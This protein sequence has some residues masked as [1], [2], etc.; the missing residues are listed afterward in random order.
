[1]SIVAPGFANSTTPFY[2]GTKCGNI[3]QTDTY[4]T[5]GAQPEPI[6]FTDPATWSDTQSFTT[7]DDITWECQTTGVYTLKFNQTFDVTNTYTPPNSDTRVTPSTTFYLDISGNLEAP[8]VGDLLVISNQGAQSSVIATVG[9]LTE[10][11]LM[12][13]FTSPVGF[14]SSTTVPGADWDLV[15]MASTDGTSTPTSP[16]TQPVYIGQYYKTTTQNA[17]T[18]S[19]DVT[20]DGTASWNNANGYITHTNGTADFTCQ[21]AGVYQLEL[22]LYM[23]ANGSTWT[24]LAKDVAINITRIGVAEQQILRNRFSVQTSVD[25]SN[26]LVGTVK[27]EAGDVIQNVVTQTVTGTPLIQGL[28]NTFD[29][30]TTFT[31]KVI[32]ELPN[33]VQGMNSLYYSVY[34]VDADGISDP[35]TILDGSTLT[36]TTVNTGEYVYYHIIQRI[37]PIVLAS[38]TRRIQIKLFANFFTA[39]TMTLVFRQ[40][41]VPTIQTSIS[42][43][44]LAPLTRDTVDARITV[45]SATTEFNQVFSSSVPITMTQTIGETLT[46]STSVNA[47]ANLFAGDTIECTLTSVE[48]KVEVSSGETTLPAPS[49]TLQWN[50]LAEGPYGNPDIIAQAQP[51]VENYGIQDL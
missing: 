16:P 12:A 10:D 40:N 37:P 43:Q 26:S 23:S 25:W 35:V 48:G 20:F 24:T 32:E 6:G 51:A 13:T 49:N 46:Y 8:A 9:V 34:A 5:T 38:L 28:Q 7:A 42:Q 1:M 17:P 36:P 21:Q 41:V 11:V 33:T 3:T 14:V 39:S 4:T 47:I 44:D 15:V 31:F 30:N 45:T 29:Y 2:A 18:G 19:T 27:L 50:L 22:N